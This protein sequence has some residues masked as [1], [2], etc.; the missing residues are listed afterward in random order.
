MDLEEIKV[1]NFY[2]NNEH[3]KYMGL[4]PLKDSY[5]L[6]IIKDKYNG[7]YYLF[8]DGN[9]I[10]KVIKYF[11]SDLEISMQES[12]VYY[13]TAENRRMV[14]SKKS[15]GRPRRLCATIVNSFNGIGNY[16]FIHGSKKTGYGSAIVGNYTT[17][18]TFYQDDDIPDCASFLKIEEWCN[19]YV[20]ESSEEDLRAVEEFSCAKRKHVAYRAGDYFRVKFGRNQYTYGRILMDVYKSTKSGLQYWNIFMGRAL[21]VETFHILTNRC[22]VTIQELE[23][24]STFP[25]QHIMDNNFYYGDYKI[26]GHG[27]LP[28]NENF[29]IMY[30]RSISGINPDKI[31]FQWGTIYKEIDYVSNLLIRRDDFDIM[32]DFKNNS[33]GYSI[34]NNPKT[35]RKCIEAKSNAPYWEDYPYNSKRN[36]QSIENRKYKKLVLKQFGLKDLDKEEV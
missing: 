7:E 3:R 14:L 4:K 11:I 18:R 6:M 28:K 20:L 27:S 25:A 35:I 1:R 33:I 5:E 31:I 22:D 29:P 30:G 23:S 19:K 16:F 17:Q 15:K 13:E 2:L 21:I 24:L 26:I 9:V 32:E 12:D 36:L 10:K 8:F 34:C